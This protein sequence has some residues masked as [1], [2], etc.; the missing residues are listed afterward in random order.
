MRAFLALMVSIAAIGGAATAHAADLSTTTS[1]YSTYAPGYGYPPPP[2]VIIDDNPG[3]TMRA[4]WLAPWESRRYFP[5]TGHRPRLGRLENLH[6]RRFIPPPAESYYRSWSTSSAFALDM[7]HAG[8]PLSE[9]QPPSRRRMP[10]P[11]E[12]KN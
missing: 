12:P 2:L 11:P 1:S 7:P 5:A 6:A 10:T 8:V 9:P 3:V 4:Y